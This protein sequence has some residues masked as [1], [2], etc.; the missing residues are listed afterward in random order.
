VLLIRNVMLRNN[1]EFEGG[2][3]DGSLYSEIFDIVFF[4]LFFSFIF[5]SLRQIMFIFFVCEYRQ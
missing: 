4:S 3:G 5:Y 1:V 2:G